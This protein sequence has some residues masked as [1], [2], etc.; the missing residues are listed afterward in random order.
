MKI[1]KVTEILQR[2]SH[3]AY[4][5]LKL[6]HKNQT[7]FTKVRPTAMIDATCSLRCRA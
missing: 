3:G 4:V 1:E 6:L 2:A 5:I 7:L